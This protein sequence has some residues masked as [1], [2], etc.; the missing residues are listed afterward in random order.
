MSGLPVLSAER[1]SEV[2]ES[3]ALTTTAPRP[4][5]GKTRLFVRQSISCR[6]SC[7]PGDSGR[8]RV[9][10]HRKVPRAGSALRCHL[11]CRFCFGL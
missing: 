7:W 5:G 2:A 11:G 4:P 1:P 3:I 6:M 10:R 9:I 8:R